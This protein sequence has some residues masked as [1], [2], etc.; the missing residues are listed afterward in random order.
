VTHH[1][2]GPRAFTGNIVQLADANRAYRRV[3]YTGARTQLVVMSL[4]PGG[5]IGSETHAKVE[6]VLVCVRGEGVVQLGARRR[7][8]RE[9]DAVVVPP[10]VRHNIIERTGHSAL[11]LYTVYSPPNHLPRRVHATKA[12]AEADTADA[13]VEARAEAAGPPL[14]ALSYE[15]LY[16]D[17]HRL[18]LPVPRGG[19]SCAS[20]RWLRKEEDG[21]HCASALWQLWPRSQGG[22]GGRSRLPVDDAGT[23]C[24]DLWAPAGAAARR[25]VYIARV[26]DELGWSRKR[27]AQVAD[28]SGMFVDAAPT[29]DGMLDALVRA[30]EKHGDESGTEH[31]V[32][33]LQELLAAC[34]GAMSDDQRRDVYDAHEPSEDDDG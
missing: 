13:A 22:G 1:P 9:G 24:C 10:G 4:P 34:W 26:V 3:V 33:D 16:G 15:L 25:E 7:P 27:A 8:F 11:D 28:G 20:C 32:G 23:Y 12:D 14:A 5:E 30:A 2:R 21:P 29:T 31:E 18:G 6:Q 19:S 17:G